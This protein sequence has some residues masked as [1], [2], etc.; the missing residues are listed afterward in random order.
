MSGWATVLIGAMSSVVAIGTSNLILSFQIDDVVD[1]VA[2][3]GG[4][5]LWGVIA[6]GFFA[7]QRWVPAE[8]ILPELS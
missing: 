5:G 2:V 8:G 4:P 3:H 7:D 6:V 1:A